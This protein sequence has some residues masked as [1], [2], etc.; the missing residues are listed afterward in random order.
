MVAS[1]FLFAA[2][3]ALGGTASVT[4]T[5]V[6]YVAAPGE[7]NDVTVTMTDFG[8][9]RIYEITDAGVAVTAG[10]GCVAVDADTVTC[11]GPPTE[12][13]TIILR[14]GDLDDE[15]SLASLCP[16]CEPGMGFGFEEL[17]GLRRFRQ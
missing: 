2:D 9:P 3:V 16:S 14:A 13:D 4:A 6:L 15:V 7:A 11:T 8:P 10:A 17:R 12:F 5:D 1:C